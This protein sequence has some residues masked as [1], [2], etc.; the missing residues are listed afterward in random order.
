[1][2]RYICARCGGSGIE[3]SVLIEDT[4]EACSECDGNGW[5]T[6]NN[7]VNEDEPDVSEEKWNK[8]HEWKNYTEFMKSIKLAPH[9]RIKEN[10][11]SSDKNKKFCPNCGSEMEK[12]QFS[13]GASSEWSR[14]DCLNCFTTWI[15]ENGKMQE[16]KWK[17]W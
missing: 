5:T 16:R 7:W 13:I 2:K 15:E 1:M 3:P 11:S 8:M 4:P 17:R 12:M 9:N 6:T 10:V 14:Y